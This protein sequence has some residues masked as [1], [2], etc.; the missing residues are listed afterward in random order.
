MTSVL[1]NVVVAIV[2]SLVI[3][4]TAPDETAAADYEDRV[5]A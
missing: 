2:L 3:R 5:I 4:S 1:A